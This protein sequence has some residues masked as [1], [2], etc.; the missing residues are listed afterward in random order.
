MHLRK[1]YDKFL[2]ISYFDIIFFSEEMGIKIVMINIR[3]F[4]L[5]CF[6]VVKLPLG[7]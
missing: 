2:F 5:Q 6:R 3:K 1:F 7:E 4:I